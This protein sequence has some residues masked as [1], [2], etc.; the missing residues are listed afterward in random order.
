MFKLFR[1]TIRFK[2]V[3]S[4]RGGRFLTVYHKGAPVNGKVISNNLLYSK[5]QRARDGKMFYIKNWSVSLVCA[6]HRVH[7]LSGDC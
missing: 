7:F 4:N 6:D 3:L 2:R 1:V 5:V